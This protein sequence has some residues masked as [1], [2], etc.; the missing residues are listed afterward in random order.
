MIKVSN[1]KSL[2]KDDFE[3]L[4]GTTLFEQMYRNR[5]VVT[6]NQDGVR[7]L[8]WSWCEANCKGFFHVDTGGKTFLTFFE[9]DADV[10]AFKLRFDGV[11]MEDLE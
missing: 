1:P 6:S 7:F 11:R 5:C 4:R 9:T 10:V 3:S 8:V 2:N